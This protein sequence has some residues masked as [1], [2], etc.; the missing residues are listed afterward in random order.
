MLILWNNLSCLRAN[1]DSFVKCHALRTFFLP[2]KINF[3]KTLV[4]CTE[5]NLHT[6]S[7]GEG[8]TFRDVVVVIK[9]L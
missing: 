2:W 1:D 4:F 6:E 9:W 5:Y 8:A 7:K 3:S